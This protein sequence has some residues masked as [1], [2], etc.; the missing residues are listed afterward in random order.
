M[1]KSSNELIDCRI[2]DD[3]L[4]VFRMNDEEIEYYIDIEI[5]NKMIREFKNQRLRTGNFKSEPTTDN[6]SQLLCEII[7]PTRVDTYRYETISF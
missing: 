1:L 4:A 7:S 3:G 6:Y 5:Y 2:T